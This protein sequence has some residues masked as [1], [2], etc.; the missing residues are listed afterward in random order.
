MEEARQTVNSRS[1]IA[2]SATACNRGFTYQ[3]LLRA[4]IARASRG[5][6]FHAVAEE[7]LVGVNGDLTKFQVKGLPKGPASQGAHLDGQVQT[8]EGDPSEHLPS[9]GLSVRDQVIICKI[10]REELDG[11]PTSFLREQEDVV[12]VVVRQLVEDS[13]GF[14]ALLELDAKADLLLSRPLQGSGTSSISAA[15]VGQATAGALGI[16]AGFQ[17]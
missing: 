7:R 14:L 5:D 16:K 12:K 8:D 3:Q 2:K 1:L 17:G 13:N 15:E 11:Q 9:F 6:G 4:R 10:K